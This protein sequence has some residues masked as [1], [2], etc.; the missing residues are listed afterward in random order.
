MDPLKGCQEQSRAG[1]AWLFLNR[2]IYDIY[3]YIS[4][5]VDKSICSICCGL[6]YEGRVGVSPSLAWLLCGLIDSVA[7][8]R[9]KNDLRHPLLKETP[10]IS[11][12][13][14]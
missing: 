1:Q 8:Q 6:F 12:I 9:S 11:V 14:S 4:M 10:V 2:Y 5:N 3:K 13:L 7:E